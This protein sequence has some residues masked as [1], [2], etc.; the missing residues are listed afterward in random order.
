MARHHE[1]TADDGEETAHENE[2]E[3]DSDVTACPSEMSV[4]EREK[5][6][7]DG[8]PTGHVQ[9][10][11]PMA[12]YERHAFTAVSPRFTV[13]S[14][15]VTITPYQCTIMGQCFAVISHLFTAGGRLFTPNVISLLFQRHE[16]SALRSCA[17]SSRSPAVH[18][19]HCLFSPHFPVI[20][21]VVDPLHSGVLGRLW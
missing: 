1:T 4:Y 8:K 10:K 2:F 15:C 13:T 18:H 12:M 20:L 3:R 14:R 19:G 7:H 16:L 5:R 21:T 17:V 6:A 11:A 9:W